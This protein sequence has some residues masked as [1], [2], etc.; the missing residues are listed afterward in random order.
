[1]NCRTRPH[2]ANIKNG[3]GI[4]LNPG[5]AKAFGLTPPFKIAGVQWD[6]PYALYTPKE[7]LQRNHFAAIRLGLKCKMIFEPC[8][9]YMSCAD[10]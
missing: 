2:R 3:A 9:Y 8:R 10:S 4:D 6:W 1:V 7:V 5:F